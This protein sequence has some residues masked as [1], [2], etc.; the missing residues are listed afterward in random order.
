MEWIYLRMRLTLYLCS[1]VLGA[2]SFC[3]LQESS[4]RLIDEHV[5]G[6]SCRGTRHLPVVNRRLIG[7]YL[8]MILLEDA[9]FFGMTNTKGFCQKKNA[10]GDYDREFLIVAH[11]NC[12]LLLCP[13]F[14]LSIRDSFRPT[15]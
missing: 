5:V 12:I 9:S 14:I 10:N 13:D 1:F 8:K 4:C 15:L 6:L 11:L 3:L 7:T 2:C